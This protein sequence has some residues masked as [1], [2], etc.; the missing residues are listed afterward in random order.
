MHPTSGRGV[1]LAVG[2]GGQTDAPE[3]SDEERAVRAVEWALIAARRS[4]EAD[5]R[6]RL[7]AVEVA[8]AEDELR[9]RRNAERRQ[10][11]VLAELARGRA[12]SDRAPSGPGAMVDLA[13]VN[14]DDFR[15]ERL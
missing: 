2:V 9:A 10:R 15:I 11:G 13:A 4:A 14:L 5:R 3:P 1:G 6:R 7:R 8:I 12:A